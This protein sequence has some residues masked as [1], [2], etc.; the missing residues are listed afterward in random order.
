MP[1]ENS[2]G[3]TIP[4]WRRP[5][6][7]GCTLVL[8]SAYPHPLSL[9]GTTSDVLGTPVSTS[10]VKRCALPCFHRQRRP[11][12]LARLGFGQGRTG[13][14]GVKSACRDTS[15]TARGGNDGTLHHRPHQ[16][17]FASNRLQ[18]HHRLNSP[19]IRSSSSI[20]TPHRAEHTG[21]GAIAGALTLSRLHSCAEYSRA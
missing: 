4:P 5:L 8:L 1:V 6:S 19:R 9:T 7:S 10:D 12:P 20:R 3:P 15:R 18:R 13:Q 11:M 2:R 21:R 14:E 17:R 16:C